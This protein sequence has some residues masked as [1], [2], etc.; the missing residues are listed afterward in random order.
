[1]GSR[2][3]LDHVEKRNMLL[4]SGFELRNP[5]ADYDEFEKGVQN[6][7]CVSSFLA[8]TPPPKPR[9]SN[10]YFETLTNRSKG[11]GSGRSLDKVT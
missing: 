6:I 9:T 10:C 2:T 11:G 4:L 8:A 1:V 7:K 3:G 5:I